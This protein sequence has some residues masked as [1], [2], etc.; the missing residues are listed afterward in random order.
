M[1]YKAVNALI[2]RLYCNS[3]NAG[4]N[5]AHGSIDSEGEAA[6][7]ETFAE[8]NYDLVIHV[9]MA[10]KRDYY[11]LEV[12]ARRGLYRAPDVDG[13]SCPGL[14]PCRWFD[15]EGKSQLPS[16]P[17]VLI[18]EDIDFDEVLTR[19]KQRVGKVCFWCL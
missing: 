8:N 16:L 1:C 15:H 19:W 10:G 2:P 17:E 9:G 6:N 14:V 11:A 12:Q 5:D 4:H 3:T 7:A 13:C 18:S